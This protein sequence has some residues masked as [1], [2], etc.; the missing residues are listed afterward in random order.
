MVGDNLQVGNLGLGILVA[1]SLVEGS[2]L[3]VDKS[4]RGI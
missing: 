1:D 2:T 3:A 4:Q